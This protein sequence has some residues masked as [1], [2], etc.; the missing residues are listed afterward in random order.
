[1]C[2][3]AWLARHPQLKDFYFKNDNEGKRTPAQGFHAQRMG[4]RRGV[5]DF[6]IGWPTPKYH[7]LFLEVKRNKKYTE[8]ERSTET[9]IMQELFIENMKS[10]GYWGEFCYGWEDG[11]R[12][13]ECY[14]HF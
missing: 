12:I 3:V 10:V 5:S 4:L 14:L 9:W 6:F 2:L 13:I 7:G 8:S 11:K 1:M